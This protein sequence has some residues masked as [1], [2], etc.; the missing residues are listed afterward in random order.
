MNEKVFSFKIINSRHPKTIFWVAIIL[1][2]VGKNTACKERREISE[3]EGNRMV[4]SEE[5]KRKRKF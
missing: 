4:Y 5:Y 2:R 1:S 3:V